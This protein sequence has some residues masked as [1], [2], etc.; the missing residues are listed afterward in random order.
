MQTTFLLITFVA[1]LGAI[2][3]L[4]LAIALIFYFTKKFHKLGLSALRVGVVAGAIFVLAW[5]GLTFVFISNPDHRWLSIA[6]FFGSG[7]ALGSTFVLVKHLIT[8]HTA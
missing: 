7:F 2:S 6:I 8:R 5:A 4:F 1:A 3:P